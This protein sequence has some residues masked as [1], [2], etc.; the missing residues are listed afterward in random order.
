MGYFPEIYVDNEIHPEPLGD[1]MLDYLHNN[2]AEWANVDFKLTIDI[3]RTSDFAKIA[4]D[5]FAMANWGGGWLLFGYIENANRVI[6]PKG[7]DDSFN[8]DQATIQEKFESYCSDSIAIDF[9]PYERV[10]EENGEDKKKLFAAMFIKPSSKILKPSKDGWYIDPK[11]G[12]KK[13]VFQKND[14]ITRRGTKNVIAT[15][16]EIIEIKKRIDNEEYRISLL[17]GNPDS[18]PEKITSNL[19]PVLKLPEYIYEANLI[20]GDFPFSET[21]HRPYV[22]IGRRIFTFCDLSIPSLT[23]FFDPNSLSK[24]KRD[25]FLQDPDKQN[26]II[27]L[28]NLEIISAM[29]TKQLTYDYNSESLFFACDKSDRIEGWGLPGVGRPRKVSRFL[30]FGKKI[31]CRHYSVKLRFQV[32]GNRYYLRVNP[33]II[34]SKNGKNPIRR[35]DDGPIITRLVR[36]RHNRVFFL[37]LQFW[38]SYIPRHASDDLT[39]DLN[40][41]ILISPHYVSSELELGIAYDRPSREQKHGYRK[42]KGETMQSWNIQEPQLIFGRN[43]EESDPRLGMKYF[44]PYYPPKE[45]PIQQMKVGMV[46]TGLTIDLLKDFIE[47]LKKYQGS[48]NAN[49]FL[50]PDFPGISP[51]S[52]FSCD[53]ITSESWN[54]VITQA[55]LN[56]LFKTA[57]IDP[58]RFVEE[59]IAKAV[60]IYVTKIRNISIEDSPP[61][62]ILCIIPK[63]LNHYCGI[64]PITQRARKRR[65]QSKGKKQVKDESQKTLIDYGVEK[66][67]ENFDLRNAIKGKVMDYGIPVQFL[68]EEKAR[69]VLSF[70][71]N[72][73]VQD[74][75]TFSWNIG[76]A[77]YYKCNGKPWRLAKLESRTCY[78]GIAFYRNRLDS[79]E[80]IQASMAQVFTSSGDGFVLRGEEVVVD[81]E[82]KEP[83]LTRDK[84]YD[85][86]SHAIDEYS[87]K[88][89]TKPAR[90]VVHKTS[91]FTRDERMGVIDAINRASADLVSIKRELEI[92]FVRTG[93]YPV[94]RGTMIKLAENTYL[95]YTS[96]YTSRLRT[97]PGHRIPVPLNLQMD[98]DS[99][100]NTVAEEILKLTKINWNT[101]VYADKFP[102]TLTFPRQVGKVLSELPEGSIIQNHYR[103]YM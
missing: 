93:N 91:A 77:M 2:R 5:I 63:E 59:R 52:K 6:I 16:S 90:V 4:E 22:K 75:A 83:H 103:Y 15:D 42:P 62:V 14:I 10:V 100:S 13:V 84:T 92:R 25:N 50:F 37:D 99:D 47:M 48:R 79:R 34:L 17:K 9:K 32:I 78:I 61:A 65:L 27:R 64:S 49:H 85:L 71:P 95:L 81:K 73:K 98:C 33:G 8:A 96:G 56:Q 102:I 40:R 41:R 68:Q 35:F 11:S 88:V 86:V 24:Q 101:T 3:S 39:I 30:K 60:K 82:T 67:P 55:D 7:L 1:L 74:P 51:S 66:V 43:K 53:I 94:L 20:S 31:R 29:K 69:D 70:G 21:G 80:Y 44:G 19:L 36:R 76:A 57:K 26:L 97:Y 72:S 89:N 28:L 46:A 23:R 54:E 87:T 12:K 18:I 58:E 38:L 45:R